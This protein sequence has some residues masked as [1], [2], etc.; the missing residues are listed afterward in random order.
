MGVV[1][2]YLDRN[3]HQLE[4]RTIF[5]SNLLHIAAR[6]GQVA[7]VEELL[8]RGSNVDALDFVSLRHPGHSSI[9]QCTIHTPFRLLSAALM[10]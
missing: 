1:Q 7:V 5:Q 3:P 8:K 4:N 10:L 2:Q 6:N 9:Q